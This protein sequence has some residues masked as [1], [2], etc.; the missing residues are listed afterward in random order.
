V[1]VDFMRNVVAGY[2][3][4]L[5]TKIDVPIEELTGQI[6]IREKSHLRT[7]KLNLR[8]I[9][10]LEAAA[11]HDGYYLATGLSNGSCQN[12]LCN[13]AECAVIALGQKCRF[14]LEARPSIESVGIDAFMLATKVGWDVYPIG[15]SLPPP[16]IKYGVTLGLVLIV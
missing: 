3:Y 12:V 11:F 6:A 9:N 4:A 10:D 5:F 15:R 1:D 13:G 2:K 14:P 7:S 8:I 16:K